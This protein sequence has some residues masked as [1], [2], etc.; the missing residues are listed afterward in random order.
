MEPD[1]LEGQLWEQFGRRVRAHREQRGWSQEE[2]GKRIGMVRQQ[3]NRIEQGAGTKRSTVVRIAEA[4]E[5]P[6]SVLF[7]WAGWRIPASPESEERLKLMAFFDQLPKNQRE[8]LIAIGE[9]LWR[10]YG[11][12]NDKTKHAGKN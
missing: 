5:L 4:L 8:D 12:R 2:C 9:T 10:R 7:E 1:L 3:W 6:V 11:Q